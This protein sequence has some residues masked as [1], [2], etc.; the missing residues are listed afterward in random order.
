MKRRFVTKEMVATMKRME[1]DGKT[2]KEIAEALDVAQSTV[3]R[4]LGAVQ[5]YRG[6]RMQMAA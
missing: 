6:A 3:T 5:Q 4:S 2:R 1:A